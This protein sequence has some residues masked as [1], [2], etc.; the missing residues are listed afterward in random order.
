MYQRFTTKT[1]QVYST[2]KTRLHMIRVDI[3]NIFSLPGDKHTLG[4]CF[5]L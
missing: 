1:Y 3:R 4:F 5:C 2:A